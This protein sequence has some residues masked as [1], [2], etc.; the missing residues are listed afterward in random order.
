MN[1]KSHSA[2]GGGK[3]GFFCCRKSNPFNQ[4]HCLVTVLSENFLF[5]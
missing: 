3:E 2:S 4:V 5:F 1:S